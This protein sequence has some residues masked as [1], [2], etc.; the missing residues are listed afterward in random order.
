MIKGE[1]VILRKKHPS[2]L[3]NDYIWRIDPDLI[4]LDA[5]PPLKLSRREYISYS[6]DEIRHPSKKRYRLAI[7]SD[8]GKHIGNCMY[9]DIDE[10]KSQA[11][12]GVLIGDSDYQGQGYGT[13][14]VKTLVQYIFDNTSLQRIYLKTLVWNIRAY[15]CFHKCGFTD[16]GRI[17]SNGNDFILMELQRDTVKTRSDYHTQ[18]DIKASLKSIT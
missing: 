10:K 1:R 17:T 9:Y 3:E 12:L 4:A 8:D 7:D 11:E 6:N 13:D 18:A 2:D 16:C 14:A 15:K 5:A